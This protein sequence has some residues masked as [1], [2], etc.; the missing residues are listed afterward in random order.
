VSEQ[1]TIQVIPPGLLI[2]NSVPRQI[3]LNRPFSG[4]VVAVGAFLPTHLQ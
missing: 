2:A 1:V 3:L 4:K